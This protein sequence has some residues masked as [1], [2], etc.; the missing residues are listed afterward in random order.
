MKKSTKKVLI[1][2]AIL[3]GIAMLVNPSYSSVYVDGPNGPI[4]TEKWGFGPGRMFVHTRVVADDSS[5]T[6]NME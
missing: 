6:I 1:A 2:G 5:V 3:L 4:K